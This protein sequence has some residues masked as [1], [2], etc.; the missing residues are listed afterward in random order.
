MNRTRLTY[1]I[2]TLRKEM[3]EAFTRSLGDWYIVKISATADH[4]AD[5]FKDRSASVKKDLELYRE[6]MLSL[7]NHYSCRVLH[8]AELARTKGKMQEVV[9][10]RRV[11]GKIFACAF[12]V[13]YFEGEKPTIAIKLRTVIPEYDSNLGDRNSILVNYV[14]PKIQFEYDGYRRVMSRLDR[15]IASKDCPPQLRMLKII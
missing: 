6:L 14:P 5:R 10:Y 8:Y 13:Q 1:L 7:A 12:T 3:N 15:L 11:N 2:N 4:I 9:A